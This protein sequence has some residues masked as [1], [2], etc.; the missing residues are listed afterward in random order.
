MKYLLIDTATDD[1]TVALSSIDKIYSLSTSTHNRE[2]S[3]Y[4]MLQLQKAFN[5]SGLK[6]DE[7]DKILVINGPGSFT[8]IRIGVTIAKTYA[9]ALKK[10][11]VPI[12]SLHAYTFGYDNYDYYVSVLDAKRNYVYAAVYDY[13]HDPVLAEQYISSDKLS[14]F[15]SGLDGQVIVIGDT[16]INKYKKMPRKMDILKMIQ[17]YKLIKP[18]SV[19]D[20]NP[21][22]LKRVEAEEK[23]IEGQ[24]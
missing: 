3:K 21:R 13:N 2:H 17:Y 14:D 5:E 9:W 12:S 6:P 16:N 10:D 11:I 4:A 18:V 7:I 20:L 22:Y 19:H 24:K 1:L 15:I 23:L 8:G